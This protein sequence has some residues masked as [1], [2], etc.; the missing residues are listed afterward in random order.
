[1]QYVFFC[2]RNTAIPASQTEFQLP[3]GFVF[4]QCAHISRFPGT[5]GP[6]IVNMQQFWHLQRDSAALMLIQAGWLSSHREKIWQN[7]R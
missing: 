1:M 2:K 5:T 6:L 4:S 7:N 3:R